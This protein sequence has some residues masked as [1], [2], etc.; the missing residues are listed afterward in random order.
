MIGDASINLGRV[1]SYGRKLIWNF[2]TNAAIKLGQ[3]QQDGDP[4]NSTSEG[5]IVV[6]TNAAGTFDYN[7]WAFTRIKSTRIG[8]NNCLANVQTYIFR[9]D[10]LGMYLKDDAGVK[11]FEHVRATKAG[12]NM[13]NF[14]IGTSSFGAAAAKCLALTNSA[15]PPSASA[16]LAH[17]FA[18][19]AAGAGTAALAIFQEFAPYDGAGVPSTT[20][21]PVVVNGVTY[22]I[23]ATTVA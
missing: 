12:Y 5:I 9:A 2:G 21:I 11:T 19:D 1:D 8:I 17:L 20:K 13:G 6:G 15:T 16:D 23:L 14:G 3:I 10:E 7:N 22:Y 18:Q 4:Q